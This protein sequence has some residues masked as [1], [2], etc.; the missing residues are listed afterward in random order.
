MERWSLSSL[1]FRNGV[2]LGAAQR[3]SRWWVWRWTSSWH[4]YDVISFLPLAVIPFTFFSFIHIN[5]TISRISSPLCYHVPGNA[6][7]PGNG[8]MPSE[9]TCSNASAAF[10][11]AAAA[12]G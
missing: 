6:P 11:S 8:G 5:V 4:V 9:I 1:C 7:V 2:S 10:L 12:A 3:Q